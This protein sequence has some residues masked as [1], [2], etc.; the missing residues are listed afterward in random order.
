MDLSITML[1]FGHGLAVFVPSLTVCWYGTF[2]HFVDVVRFDGVLYC[3]QWTD[4]V[5][6]GRKQI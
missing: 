5:E 2:L 1:F 6:A 3:P 4:H